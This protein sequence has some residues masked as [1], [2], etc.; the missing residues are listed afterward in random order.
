M[1]LL[2]LLYIVFTWV[3]SYAQLL[4]IQYDTLKR[5]NEII[6]NTY[7]DYSGSSIERDI[8]QKFLLT[9]GNIDSAMKLRSFDRHGGVNRFGVDITAELEYRAYNLTPFKKNDD[10]GMVFKAGYTTFGGLLYSKDLFGITMYGNAMYVGDTADLSGLDVSLT[11]FQ[12][13]GFGL[14]SNRSKSSVV[15]NLYN[16]NQRTTAHFRDFTMIQSADGSSID[17]E[18]DG[19]LTSGSNSAYMQGLGFGFDFDFKFPIS[20][21][22][23]EKA[24]LQVQAKNV[25]VGFML[26]DQTRY[27]ADTTIFYD[28]FTIN[29]LVGPGSIFEDSTINVMDTLGITKSTVRPAFLLPGFIQVAKIV[30]DLSTKKLQSFYGFRMYP[31]LIYSPYIFAGLDYR[32]AEW[33][34]FGGQMSYGG[35]SR[36]KVGLYSDVH[37]WKLNLGLGTENLLGF[38][39]KKANGQSLLVRLRCAF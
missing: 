13:I 39:S 23:D 7:G 24:F 22:E 5:N 35:F 25:G 18:V 21:K 26:E 17:L 20:W 12:K 29:E 28:G 16:I 36:F 30:D 8:S 27:S 19:T 2:A 3:F 4:P 11:S 1:R 33:L 38:V 37:F 34:R 14:I 32:P 10:Y 6:I 9:G 15:F 31:T